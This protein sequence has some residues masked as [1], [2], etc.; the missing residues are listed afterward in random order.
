MML[1]S[2]MMVM[3]KIG[4]P[5]FLSTIL[6]TLLAV[7]ATTSQ[8]VAALEYTLENHTFELGARARLARVDAEENARAASLLIRFR[9]T[10]EWSQQFSTLFEIGR[11]HV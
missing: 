2:S 6:I 3:P 9:A 4:K 5:I 10:S 7:I 8:P 11:A 1:L